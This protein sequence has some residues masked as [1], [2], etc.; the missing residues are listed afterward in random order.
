[1]SNSITK[2]KFTPAI[3]MVGYTATVWAK[4]FLPQRS[5]AYI[6]SKVN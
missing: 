5:C 6:E 3:K 1:M 4:I 2:N